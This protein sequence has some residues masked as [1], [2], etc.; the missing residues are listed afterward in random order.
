MLLVLLSVCKN[1]H[2]KNDKLALNSDWLLSNLLLTSPLLKVHTV[3][4]G[5][6]TLDTV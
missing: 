1:T 4:C 3:A 5:Q 2:N 6:E